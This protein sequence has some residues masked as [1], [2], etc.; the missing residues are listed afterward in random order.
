MNLRDGLSGPQIGTALA[1]LY[2]IPVI[3]VTANPELTPSGEAGFFG[4]VAK[5]YT[6]AKLAATV[7]RVARSVD[8]EAA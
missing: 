2:G 8:D 4:I 7:R 3:F 1:G 6:N 5:P